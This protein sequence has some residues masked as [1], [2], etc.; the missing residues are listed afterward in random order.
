ML[1]RRRGYIDLGAE[2][3]IMAAE[4]NNIKIAVE[5]KSFIGNSDLDDFED[6]LG[7]FLLYWK[8]LQISEPDRVL[9][10]ALPLGFYNR[11]FDDAFFLDVAKSFDIK[12]IVFNETQ[13]TIAKWTK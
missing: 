5:I 1:G 12:M 10:L 4:R 3:E 9:Y 13:P 2:R 11:F 7:Q 6:A 8:A